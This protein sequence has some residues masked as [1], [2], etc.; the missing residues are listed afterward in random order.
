[1]ASESI[2]LDETIMEQEKDYLTDYYD[3]FKVHILKGAKLDEEIDYLLR[4]A[5]GGGA[6]ATLHMMK[7]IDDGIDEVLDADIIEKVLRDDFERYIK[8]LDEMHAVL[9]SENVVSFRRMDD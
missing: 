5:V 6:H 9:N 1:M 4:M 8:E 2:L 7:V 3:W